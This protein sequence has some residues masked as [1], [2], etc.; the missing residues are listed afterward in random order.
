MKPIAL[1]INQP[2]FQ[3]RH[4]PRGQPQ[5]LHAVNKCLP[6]LVV[7]GNFSSNLLLFET[8]H[9]DQS[10]R[11]WQCALAEP[12]PYRHHAAA[13]RR[14]RSTHAAHPWSISLYRP[15]WQFYSKQK[16]Y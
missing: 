13:S 11:H 12:A 6:W 7:G 14:R 8:T 10:I 1:S 16:Q 5:R 2:N 4:R 3:V 15:T 9:V